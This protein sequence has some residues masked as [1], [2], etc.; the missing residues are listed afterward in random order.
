MP[1]LIEDGFNYR[2][3]VMR[4]ETFPQA[5]LS[6]SGA[7]LRG[8]L[9]KA[10][11]GE[12]SVA[13]APGANITAGRLEGATPDPVLGFALMDGERAASN[14]YDP[15]Q[16]L[17]PGPYV[18]FALPIAHS[19]HGSSTLSIT[20]LLAQ[21]GLSHMD[22]SIAN[23]T[24][25]GSTPW[26]VDIS[27]TTNPYVR[28]VGMFTRPDWTVP[29]HGGVAWNATGEKFGWVWARFNGTGLQLQ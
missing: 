2:G 15:V 20:Q 13:K 26:V 29:G 24:R 28:V 4:V 22:Q 6:A 25:Q 17:I 11:N 10:A 23:Y 9:V 16:V 18:D 27:D 8:D 19:T 3:E 7:F 14:R 12:V 21:Y 1:T 5:D